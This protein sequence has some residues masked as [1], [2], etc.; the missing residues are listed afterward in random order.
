M[1]IVSPVRKQG[2]LL[3]LQQNHDINVIF[4]GGFH[5]NIAMYAEWKGVLE[6]LCSYPLCNEELVEA[7]DAPWR[8]LRLLW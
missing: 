7:K 6:E 1:K 3:P 5:S 2:L 4:C 8:I